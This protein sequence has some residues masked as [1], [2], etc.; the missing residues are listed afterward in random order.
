MRPWPK[1]KFGNF[2][3]SGK[4]RYW[5]VLKAWM[6][7][8]EMII[9][10]FGLLCT[11]WSKLILIHRNNPPNLFAELT[12]VILADLLFFAFI[13]LIIRCLYL[14]KPSALSARCALVIA[15]V[16]SLWSIMN[17]VWLIKSGVQLQPG[18]L[19][20]FVRDFGDLWPLVHVH[21]KYSIIHI[22][23]LAVVLPAVCGYFLWRFIRP[24][25][26]AAL[27][28]YHAHHVGTAM[29][30]I[31]VLFFAQFVVK[32]NTNSSFPSQV[33]SFS[34]HWYALVST[35]TCFSKRHSSVEQ[36]SNVRQAGE[37]QIVLP[38]SPTQNLPNVVFILLESIP[39]CVTSM[40]DPNNNLTPY[41]AHL[42][43]EGVEFVSTYAPTPYTTK[44]FW[45][46]LTSTSPIITTDNVESI[47][48]D[49]PYEGLPSLLGR[50]GYRCGFFEMSKGSFGCAAGFFKNLAFDWAWFRENLEDKSAYIGYMGGD[51]CRMIK[52]AL[53]WA[54]NGTKPFFLMMI[55]SISHDPYEV[56]AWF[57]RCKSTDVKEKYLHTVRY[58]DYFLEEFFHQLKS[59]GLNNNTIVSITGDHGTS[60]RV[61][62]ARG[63]WVPYEEVIRVPW[64]IHWPGHIK[65]GQIIDWPC[66]QM[67]FTPTILKLIGFDITEAEFEGRDALMPIESNRRLY[68]S[69]LLL[70][71]PIGFIEGSSKVIYWPSLNNA[72]EYNLEKD[73]EEKKPE[74][75]SRERKERIERDI[76]KWQNKTQI[77]VDPKHHT[78]R[79]LYSHWQTFSVGRSAWAYY[80]P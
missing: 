68:F 14:L 58:T 10:T 27:C 71:S 80:V 11:F 47:A 79:F 8:T 57:G 13:V 62:I 36:S 72:Y 76:E 40:D 78:R 49:Q 17:M 66:S 61:E 7:R 9:L 35:V 75:V 4:R 63:R 48:V 55:T 2:R 67:D 41:L 30:S 25:K 50:A 69:S 44:A 29:V 64:I 33:L 42:A 45:A 16:V 3:L 73:P 24:V 26:V 70:N 37:C 39:H 18:I 32:A 6:P 53:D 52:P 77:Y 38:D 31:A 5:S 19:L 28:A 56:P 1:Q 65:P 51:D 15:V 74:M 22:V 59:C 34:S 12:Y 60:F 54:S 43:S 20:V 23:F 21:I 46:T